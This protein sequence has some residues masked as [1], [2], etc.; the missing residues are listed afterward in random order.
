MNVTKTETKYLKDRVVR[1]SKE[2]YF[3]RSPTSPLDSKTPVMR[4]HVTLSFV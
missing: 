3:S 2:N 4:R 1:G